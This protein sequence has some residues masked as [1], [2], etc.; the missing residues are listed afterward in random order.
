MCVNYVRILS[1]LAILC[2]VRRSGLFVSSVQ[3]TSALNFLKNFDFRA[4]NL[5]IV[6]AEIT[7]KF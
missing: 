4:A 2:T 6:R 3:F 5:Q 7:F 1:Q